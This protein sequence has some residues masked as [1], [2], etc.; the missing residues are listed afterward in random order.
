MEDGDEEHSPSTL[1]F[2]LSMEIPMAATSST[3]QG[4]ISFCSTGHEL[5]APVKDIASGGR[6][7][8]LLALHISHSRNRPWSRLH[9]SKYYSLH[10][11]PCI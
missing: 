6:R 10:L 4:G 7:V 2:N 5:P 8:V 1:A 3:S 9:T 11:S